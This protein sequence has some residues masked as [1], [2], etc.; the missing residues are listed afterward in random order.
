MILLIIWMQGGYEKYTLIIII[1]TLTILVFTVHAHCKL[2]PSII[3]CYVAASS[4]IGTNFPVGCCNV[5]CN[6][7][8][9]L[10]YLQKRTTFLWKAERCVGCST[11]V[12]FETSPF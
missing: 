8:N 10:I 9:F 1:I 7:V 12:L 6:V 2:K 4:L 11:R 5:N 3:L